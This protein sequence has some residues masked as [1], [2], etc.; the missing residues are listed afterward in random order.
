MEA[1]LQKERELLTRWRF[2]ATAIGITQTFLCSGIVFGWSS[3]ETILREEG[4]FADAADPDMMFSMVFTCGAIGNY[5]SNMPWGYVLD[6]RGPKFTGI[7]SAVVFAAGIA[8]CA[9]AA[10]DARLLMAGFALIGWAGPAIQLPTLCF[11]C[12]FPGA[13]AV[14]PRLPPLQRSLIFTLH[15]SRLT[16]A[17]LA[18]FAP[19]AAQVVMSFQAA[20][21]DGGTA[22]FYLFKLAKTY[23]VSSHACFVAY[24]SF[25]PLFVLLPAVALWPSA[26]LD[27]AP[28][29]PGPGSS[30]F[31][32]ALPTTTA[33]ALPP[34]ARDDAN[35]QSAAG[36]APS[37]PAVPPSK[38][39]L[40]AKI[41]HPEYLFLTLFTAVH[42]LK[43]GAISTVNSW[44]RRTRRTR[45]RVTAVAAR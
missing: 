34:A 6:T 22:V 32:K 42:I 24:L 44:R 16:R 14:R 43:V 38:L 11:T 45:R 35:P 13:G 30:P 18:S 12:L 4:L 10:L 25:V 29:T 21:F 33:K 1:K 3:L 23:G 9:G 31:L 15:A 26:T 40:R 27:A 17:Q 37:P 8:L 20:C 19:S 28:A 36:A 39:P 41:A 2:T 7:A 5:L